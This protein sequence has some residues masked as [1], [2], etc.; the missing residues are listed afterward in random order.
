MSDATLPVTA[1]GPRLTVTASERE[2]T[3]SERVRFAYSETRLAILLVGPVVVVV[4]LFLRDQVE[5]QR[6]ANWCIALAAAY[7]ARLLLGVLHARRQP[8]EDAQAERK[9]TAMFHATIA[10]S[11]FAWSLLVWHVLEEAQPV[12]RLS[13]VAV[14][15]A[16]AAAALRGLSTLPLAYALF[17][18]AMLAP[19]A[20]PSIAT[21]EIA[22]VM[23]GV[24]LILFLAAMTA[25]VHSASLEF[26]RRAV[27][28]ADLAD[29]LV[30]HARA[31]AEAEA[32]N[33]AKSEFLANMS[34]EIRT[35]MNAILGMTHLAQ[36]ARPDPVLGEHL[37]RIAVAANSLLRIINDILDLSKI[38]AGKLV[39]EPVEFE[40]DALL[41]DVLSITG[42]SAQQRGVEFRHSVAPEVPRA[43][44]AD[45]VRIGQVLSNLCANAVKFTD[46]GRVTLSVGMAGEDADHVTLAFTVEDTGIGMSAAQQRELFQ[47]FAQVDT[48]STR[49]RAGTGLGLSISIR[50]VEAMGGTIGVQSEPGRGSTFRFTVVCGRVRA[51]LDE[52]GAG[53]NLDE[54]GAG[55]N[56]ADA[57][58][59]LA[60]A[61]IL[62]V[63]DDEVNQLVAIG[64][65]EPTGAFASIASNGREA[66]R[67]IQPGKFDAV[68]MDVQMPDMDGIETTRTLRR[69]PHL[70]D[71][72]IIALTASAMAG[73]R[74]RLLEAG[75]NDFIAKP[76]R[77]AALYSTLARWLNRT[78]ARYRDR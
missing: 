45:A 57:D 69:D 43:V 71:L 20:I 49:R 68:L 21:G 4:W 54:A 18:G 28:Q 74:E 27:L 58:T 59:H 65:L 66:L 62:V 67:L 11:G 60:G 10:L 47:P 16:V 73:D 7:G 53:R 61:R 51:S 17:A 19:V 1:S 24:T 6:I 25:M 5:Q 36:Q 39:I 55:R 34:H 38:E 77:V 8:A 76:I 52:A 31:K 75:M 70:Q 9:W 14:L 78:P 13:G 63:E 44:A 72:P 42:V 50:L 33:R 56:L 37:S 35:P 22:G 30:R 3:L 26:I 32:A 48:S 46:R 40:L 12:L 15:I 23:L 2:R 41:R 64:M 29:L